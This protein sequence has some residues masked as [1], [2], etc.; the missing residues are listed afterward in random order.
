MHGLQYVIL[1]Y[2]RTSGM[3]LVCLSTRT[4][5]AKQNQSCFQIY[6]LNM[7]L[8]ILLFAMRLKITPKSSTALKYLRN[9]TGK[10]GKRYHTDF[11]FSFTTLKLS[12]IVIQECYSLN[13]FSITHILRCLIFSALIY[14]QCDFQC[15]ILIVVIVAVVSSVDDDN[16]AGVYDGNRPIR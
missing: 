12:T 8:F 5:Y 16:N 6:D 11:F 3:L 9:H 14:C 15:H 4:Y 13:M 10:L 1:M 7:L 2:L